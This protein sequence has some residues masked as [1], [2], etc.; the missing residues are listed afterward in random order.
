MFSKTLK[1]FQIFQGGRILKCIFSPFN[2]RLNI[3]ICVRPTGDSKVFKIFLKIFS[4][5]YIPRI[6]TKP[7]MVLDP[8]YRP[9][10]VFVPFNL[11]TPLFSFLLDPIFVAP[12]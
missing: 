1:T 10:S 6:P 2:R 7:T 5:R 11:S 8:Y 3:L 9:F 4:I 12:I